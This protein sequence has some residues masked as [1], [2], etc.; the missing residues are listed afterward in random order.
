MKKQFKKPVIDICIFDAEGIVTISGN[1]ANM[2]T[3]MENAGYAVTVYDLGHYPNLE[4]TKY[5]VFIQII[6][7]KYVLQGE[8]K[9]RK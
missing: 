2:K 3:E 6:A 5:S 9:N 8:W 1:A 4:Q 7:E